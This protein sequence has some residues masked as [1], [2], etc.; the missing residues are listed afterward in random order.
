MNQIVY[1]V[2]NS[3]DNVG[4]EI[5]DE[6]IN[7]AFI[8][9]NYLE[10]SNEAW[11]D[12]IK[13]INIDLQE[14]NFL[15]KKL[16]SLLTKQISDKLFGTAIWAFSKICKEEDFGLLLGFLIKYQDGDSEVLY[17]ILCALDNIR[18]NILGNSSSMF[19][20]EKNRI[21]AKEFIKKES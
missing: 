2:A 6:L 4:P 14:I 20:I 19:D 11:P 8:F 17:Q 18:M 21:L 9:E 7:I 16:I 5:E 15:K 13:N 1:R 3:I 10:M 12:E